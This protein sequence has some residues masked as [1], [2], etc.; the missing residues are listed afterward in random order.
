MDWRH[1]RKG[2]MIQLG[3][4]K[5]DLQGIGRAAFHGTQKL[6]GREPAGSRLAGGLSGPGVA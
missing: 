2:R 4:D 6:R 3:K 1:G 5:R